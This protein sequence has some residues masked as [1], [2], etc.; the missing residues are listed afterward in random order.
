MTFRS[1]ARS[2]ASSLSFSSSLLL[3]LLAPARAATTAGQV[4]GQVTG[5]DGKPMPG[6]AV[7]LVNDIT[8]YRQ[9]V[10]TGH[11]RDVSPLQRAAESL[12]PDDR[13]AGL[14]TRTTRTSTCAAA[15]PRHDVALAESRRPRPSR[16][17][18]TEAVE[19]E[20]DTS[21]T[22]ID[23]DKSLIERTAAAMPGRAFESIVTSTPGFSAGRER[24]LP[25][26]GRP[27]AA[28]PRH[29]RPADRRPGRDHVLELLDPGVAE[30]IEIITGGIP[31]EY[32]EKANGV[33]NLTTRSGLGTNGVKGDVSVGGARVQHGLGFGLGGR[34][35]RRFGWFA[36]RRRLALRPVPRPRFVRQLPQRRRHGPRLPAPRL[37]SRQSGTS[38]WRLT[39]NIGRTHRDVT[40]LPSQEEAGQDQS[41]V[42]N[43]WNANLGYQNVLGERARPRGAR[44]TPATIGS[45]SIRLPFDT[46]VQASQNRSLENQGVN[47]ARLEVR[48]RQRAQG[49]RSGQALP[50]QGAVL[51]PDHGPRLQRP[52]CGRVQP[53]PR[54]V[55]RDARRDSPSSSPARTPARIS[56]RSCR[57][58][59]A[60]TT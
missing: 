57:T 32:G 35:E 59:S 22:H 9:E 38:N 50:D 26:P 8:G 30:G 52:R 13:R 21:M 18:E 37:A 36:E 14:R 39:G 16:D 31:A 54:A 28:A 10:T 48:R 42:S 40:N 11:R 34:R 17:A 51:V 23:I 58:T 5:P 6:V 25:L 46:P 12:P 43:D 1:A 55:R 41:V 3:R 15:P 19:L 33:I 49:R 56:R 44:S 29:R 45:R 4:R 24:P 20:S 2:A 53:E 7:V 47:L 60:G 27:L